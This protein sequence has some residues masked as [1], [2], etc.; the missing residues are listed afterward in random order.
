M[1]LPIASSTLVSHQSSS[2]AINTITTNII[3]PS[4]LQL[5]FNNNDSITKNLGLDLSS[6]NNSAVMMIQQNQLKSAT[7]TI[8]K[9]VCGSSDDY[10]DSSPIGA[11]VLIP[12][13]LKITSD[14]PCPGSTISS[15][16]FQ[17]NYHYT[18][19][20]M[21]PLVG[22][23]PSSLNKQQQWP[24][25]FNNNMFEYYRRSSV[26][27]EHLTSSHS[28]NGGTN[29]NNNNNNSWF[30]QQQINNSTSSSNIWLSPN[31]ALLQINRRR[32]SHPKICTFDCV[33]CRKLMLHS[34]SERNLVAIDSETSLVNSENISN[35][36]NSGTTLTETGI[37]NTEP[38]QKQQSNS[39]Q[40]LPKFGSIITTNTSNIIR[41]RS[42]SSSS[43]SSSSSSPSSS[44]SSS[45]SSSLL[46]S[47]TSSSSSLTSITKSE[48]KFTNII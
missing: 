31:S 32:S 2:T 43:S 5:Q 46:L 42:G 4:K 34:M 33:Y 26:G 8:N 15:S 9:S 1:S 38:L 24:N 27:V 18:T 35:N 11:R 19:T 48:C 28:A 10:N 29:I 14:S 41:S 23:P 6:G 7:S 17:P 39:D 25:R 3:N 30:Q 40:G 44:S 20:V 45:S 22:H 47:S 37:S 21:T 12:P 36:N 16:H 13:K